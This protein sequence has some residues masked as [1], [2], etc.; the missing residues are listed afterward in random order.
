MRLFDKNCKNAGFTLVEL[1]MAMAITTIVS[2]GIVGAYRSQQKTQL[3]QKQ[4]VEMQQNIRAALLIMTSEIRMA[5]Y[6]PDGTN[7]AGIV[8]AG[9]GSDNLNRLI[10][11]Y[12][13]PDAS[14]DGLDN[15]ND[16]NTD[17]SGENLQAVEYYLYDSLG[18]GTVDLGRRNGAR[19]DAIAENIQTLQFTYLDTDGNVTTTPSDIRS[20]QITMVAT[21]DANELNY[22]GTNNTRTLTTTVKCRNLGI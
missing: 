12:F 11:T 2:A 5:G 8:N 3:A 13:N 7:N 18:D 20:I 9:D 17:E 6:D 21:T 19:L 1:L 10:F 4:S 15:N 16:G 22:T 14:S